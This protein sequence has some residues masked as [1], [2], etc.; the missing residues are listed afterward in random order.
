MKVIELYNS[1]NRR[2]VYFGRDEKRL[3]SVID[4]NEYLI[5]IDGKGLLPDPG[6]LEVFPSFMSE[7]SKE[8]NIEDIDALYGSHQDPDIISSLALW[9]G[10]C[11]DI[12]VYVPSIWTSF[13]NHFAENAEL[14]AIPDPGMKLPLGNS[15]DLELVPAHYL[16]SSATFSLYDPVA[17]ILWTG[18]IGAALLP[19]S[20]HEVFVKDFDSHV[21]YME[22]FHRRW[23]PSD[24]AKLKWI[25]RVRKLEINM[26]CPQHGS[27]FKGNDVQR[28]LDWFEKFEVAG[29]LKTID[30]E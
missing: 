13:I 4:T 12:K 5:T 3:K 15:K 19:D 28:F 7:L 11:K 21:R 30:E 23:M 1:G 16:H 14:L 8:I 25:K 18:D 27:I 26:I 9:L 29:A 24:T 6:G 22:G 17:K 10:V 20:A 2:W